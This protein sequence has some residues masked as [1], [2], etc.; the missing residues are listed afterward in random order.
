M[1]SHF[2]GRDQEL[3]QLQKN[4]EQVCAGQAGIRLITGEAG[5]GKTSLVQAFLK[6][7]SNQT[8]IQVAQSICNAQVGLCDP[9]LPFRQIAEQLITQ[10]IEQ[11]GGH[12]ANVNRVKNLVSETGK[13]LMDNAPDLIGSLIPGSNMLVKLGARLLEKEDWFK[14]LKDKFDTENSSQALQ[15]EKIAPQFTRL[16]QS[17]ASQKPVVM[18]IDNMQWLDAASASMLIYLMNHLGQAPVFILGCYRE[19][20]SALREGRVAPML[21]VAKKLL[22]TNENLYLP[23]GNDPDEQK[24]Q[25][26]TLLLDR[27]DNTF[28]QDFRKNMLQHTNANPL[29]AMEVLKSLQEKSY[30][31]KNKHGYWCSTPDLNWS[32]LPNRIQDL[33]RNRLD[34]LNDFTKEVLAVASIEGIASRSYVLSKVLEVP[35]RKIVRILSKELERSLQIMFEGNLNRSQEQWFS[36]FHFNNALTQKFIYEDLGRRERMLLHEDVGLAIEN[37][38]KNHPREVAAELSHHFLQAGDLNKSLTYSFEA[39]KNALNLGAYEEANAICEN[40]LAV[41][42]QLPDNR[43][44]ENEL[45]VLV[46]QSNAVKAITGWTSNEVKSIYLRIRELCKGLGEVEELSA[47]LFGLWACH[48]G[49]LEIKESLNIAQECLSLGERLKDNNVLIQANIAMGNSYYWKGNMAVAQA[50]ISAANALIGNSLIS[51]QVLHYGQDPRSMIDMFQVLIT[52]KSGRVDETKALIAA[53]LDNC[54]RF[55]HDFSLAIA[56]QGA[57]WSSLHI[58]DAKSALKYAK[59]LVD[60]SRKKRFIFYEGVGLMFEGAALILEQNNEAGREKLEKGYEIQ[61]KKTLCRVFESLYEYFKALSFLQ[62]AEY[63]S[64]MKVKNLALERQLKNGDLCYYNFLSKL[65]S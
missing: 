38:Y 29:F 57:A 64:M 12:Q 25:F 58:K 17:F 20:E 40:T 42:R 27:E 52:S 37:L 60:L 36:L 18:F 51:E 65:Y 26:L 31:V 45:K 46:L 21:G 49:T 9:Y 54:Q 3:Q 41:T 48:L 19:E 55:E 43:A 15:H 32:H 23:L 33:L 62:N 13:L 7:L 10:S 50:H 39:I 5:V 1:T 47:A 24:M 11:D 2:V 59:A 63:E 6:N 16:L 14:K 4:L 34:S 53:T 44:K 35:E 8:N 28:D 22:E 56:L 30:L 61:V